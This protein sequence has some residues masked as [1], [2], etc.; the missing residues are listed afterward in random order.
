MFRFQTGNR[1]II[2]KVLIK[3]NIISPLLPAI[4]LS[5]KTVVIV[6]FTEYLTV[7]Y[8]LY[9]AFDKDT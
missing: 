8:T 7:L 6:V 2:W 5:T 3:L 9:T 4:V 1:L